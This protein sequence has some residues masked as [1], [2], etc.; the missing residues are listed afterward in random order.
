MIE[1][2]PMD[3]VRATDNSFELTV[4]DKN[5]TAIDLTGGTLFFTVK[6]NATDSDADA[7]IKKDIVA[8]DTPLTGK[9]ILTLSKTDTN[10]SEGMYH[11]DAKFKDFRGILSA[12]KRGVFSVY[13]NISDRETASS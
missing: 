2:E 8:F 6:A 1:S 4:T 11:Y 7:L 5:G 3:V 9:Q 12:I 10:I 13:E